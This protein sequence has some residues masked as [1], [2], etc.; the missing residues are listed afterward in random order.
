MND[1]D[2]D[3]EDDARDYDDV[4][5]SLPVFCTSSFAYQTLSGRF[6]QDGTTPGFSNLQ[7]TEIPQLQ[8][9][10]IFLTR[11]ARSDT[12]RRFL[13]L[14][15]QQLNSLSIWAVSKTTQDQLSASEKQAEAAHLQTALG[16]LR[17]DLDLLAGKII[18]ECKDSLK[19]SLFK[20]FEVSSA[21][22]EAAAIAIAEGWSNK[23]TEGGMHFQTYRATCRRE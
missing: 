23:S 10:A 4:A 14:F 6:R 12:A 9:H 22:A 7:E 1:A 16:E 11:A 18:I 8:D 2:F 17:Q 21:Q 19:K 15:F 3:P 20:G 5:V 13:E